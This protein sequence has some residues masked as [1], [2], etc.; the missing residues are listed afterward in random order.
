VGPN[1]HEILAKALNPVILIFLVSTMLA[2]GLSL[3]VAQ[4]FGPFRNVRL[5]I[6]AAV[7]SYIISPFIAVIVSRLFGIEATLRYGL[8]LLAMAAGADAGPKLVTNAKANV[9][10]SV[11][12]LVVSLGITIFYIPLMLSLLLPE[13]HI[14][15]GPM[16]MKLCVTVALPIIAGLFLKA[17]YEL[18][19]DRL[20]NYVH[21]TASI[22][23]FLMAALIAILN[24]NAIIQLFGSGAI[25]AALIFIVVSFFIAYLLGGAERDNRLTM[26]FMHGGRNASLALMI[27]SQVFV[28]QPM[29]LV[30]I[31]VTVILMLVLL[32]PLSIYLGRR[33]GTGAG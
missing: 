10:F 8:V 17:H 13:V 4:I 12:L 19:A 7:M 25:G 6:S 2:C 33:A 23:M 5:A 11:G 9:G 30:M 26:A 31:T 21:K 3:T 29:V 14:D 18:F 32:L 28:D 20:V 22:F 24:Y 1:M 16:I 27:A 15:R